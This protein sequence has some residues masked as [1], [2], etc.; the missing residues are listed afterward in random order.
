MNYSLTCL[1]PTLVGNGE[2]LAPIDYMVELA[3]GRIA[4]PANLDIATVQQ[5]ELANTFRFQIAQ[6]LSRRTA[7]WAAREYNAWL[8][9]HYTHEIMRL[10]SLHRSVRSFAPSSRGRAP[11]F[12]DVQ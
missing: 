10:R 2:E 4:P 12:D 7:D 5:Q 1:T 8:T 6:Y 9:A 11:R 3:E